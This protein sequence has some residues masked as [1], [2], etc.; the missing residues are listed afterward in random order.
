MRKMGGEM[1]AS[2]RILSF[3][4]ASSFFV[5]PL[6]VAQSGN[7]VQKLAWACA[8]LIAPISSLLKGKVHKSDWWHSVAATPEAPMERYS[9]GRS[10]VAFH[11]A[12][13]LH[14]LLRSQVNRFIRLEGVS[15][16]LAFRRQIDALIADQDVLIQ[17]MT[18]EAQDLRRFLRLKEISWIGIEAEVGEVNV[19][20]LAKE[21]QILRDGYSKI[22]ISD[23]QTDQLMMLYGG[24]VAFLMSTESRLF[25]GVRLVMMEGQGMKQVGESHI[26]VLQNLIGKLKGLV[27]AGSISR[28]VFDE[29][30]AMINSKLDANELATDLEISQITEQ[31]LESALRKFVA[32]HLV[33]L[34]LFIE[35]S[36]ERD[37][38]MARTI[39]KQKGN[40]FVIVGSAHRLGIKSALGLESST[41][42]ESLRSQ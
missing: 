29:T 21:I 36:H 39:Q 34:N 19:K 3:V 41:Q 7:G 40:G 28:I 18:A 4:L 38:A 31:I 2:F 6:A 14:P 9:L 23:Q 32:E 1:T 33:H 20:N 13:H 25:R 24:S 10:T 8:D 12:P 11:F 30:Q 15:S 17:Q 37:V 22:G 16:P 5:S 27:E 26:E 35:N 42:V